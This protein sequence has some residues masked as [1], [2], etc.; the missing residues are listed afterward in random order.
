MAKAKLPKGLT[1]EDVQSS[2]EQFFADKHCSLFGRH[3][4]ISQSESREAA[5]EWYTDLVFEVLGE[6]DP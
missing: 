4:E 2:F 6:K 5:A 1:R 3:M